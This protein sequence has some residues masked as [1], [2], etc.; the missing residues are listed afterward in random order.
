MA[1]RVLLYDEYLPS[2]QMRKLHKFYRPVI[3][4]ECLPHWCYR[5][6]DVKTGRILPF[7]IH[8]S[9]LKRIHP[10]T[11]LQRDKSIKAQPTE[12]SAIKT[13]TEESAQPQ[14][15]TA[16]DGSAGTPPTLSQSRQLPQHNAADNKGQWNSIK[17]ILARRRKRASGPYKYKI[18][19][20]DDSHTWLQAKDITQVAPKQYY[21]TRR[22]RR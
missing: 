8:A 9:R 4:I 6:R 10:E 15:A 12:A 22:K 18:L 3:V 16:N 13:A 5:L 2:G 19:W 7:K 21:S 17:R 14:R 1:D 11:P 20:Q